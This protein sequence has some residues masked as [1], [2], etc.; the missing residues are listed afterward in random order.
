MTSGMP[1]SR[2]TT[3]LHDSGEDYNKLLGDALNIMKNLAHSKEQLGIRMLETAE[4]AIKTGSDAE[5]LAAITTK[6]FDDEENKS[7][8]PVIDKASY[9]E[10]L[11]VTL[12][13]MKRLAYGAE[14]LAIRMQEA[15]ECAI[16]AGS[17]AVAEITRKAA[18]DEEK[19]I[20]KLVVIVA[21]YNKHVEDSLKDMENIARDGEQLVILMQEAADDCTNILLRVYRQIGYT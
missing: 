3:V 6:A 19:S 8:E 1:K 13:S 14:Q 2:A 9:N 7:R 12:K 4:R 20:Q 15:A 5:S 21:F 17:D 11:E 16:E 10:L 18:D